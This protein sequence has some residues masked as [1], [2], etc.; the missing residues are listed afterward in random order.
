MPL[1]ARPRSAPPTCAPWP[2][3]LGHR[4]RTPH[5]APLTTGGRRSAILCCT[6]R[7]SATHAPTASAPLLPLHP[8][9][10]WCEAAVAR[11]YGVA[12]DEAATTRGLMPRRTRRRARRPWSRST[13]DLC[14]GV[15]GKPG[16]VGI[17]LLLMV[18]TVQQRGVAAQGLEEPTVGQPRGSVE[19][20]ASV[21]TPVRRGGDS[22]EQQRM[23]WLSCAA[24]RRLSGTT[25]DGMALQ[26]IKVQYM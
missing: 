17:P 12:A 21:L 2:T 16:A 15:A 3:A 6:P 24:R 4:R 1:R 22:V 9:S 23:A 10:S 13:G 7:L 20:H 14:G 26:R 5:A 11:R 18:L 25:A 8:S 19:E